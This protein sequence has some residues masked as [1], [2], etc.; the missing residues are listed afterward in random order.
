MKNKI[1]IFL[2]AANLGG[3]TVFA[4][5]GAWTDNNQFSLST[6]FDYSSGKYGTARTTDMLSI[7]AGDEYETSQWMFKVA[8]PY[9]QNSGTGGIVSGIGHSRTGG[10]TGDTQSGLSDTVAAASYNIY[11]GRASR[12]GID[13]T[14]KVKLNTVDAGLGIG[15]NDYAAQADAYQSFNNFTAL[16]SL[17]YKVLGSPAGISMNK[18]LYGSFGGSYQLDDKI[19]GGVDLS[20]SQSPSTTGEGHRELTAYVS[21]KINKNFKAKGYVLKGFS[22]GSPDSSLGAQIYYGF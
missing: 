5:P 9:V 4:A 7:P 14:G 3:A 12:F 15:Q 6:G 10:A 2:V 8:V 22:N 16:G 13:L 20:L 18:A 21:R 1:L 11:S 17:G 19:Y